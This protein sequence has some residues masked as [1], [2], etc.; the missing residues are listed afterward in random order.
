MNVLG[1]LFDFAYEAFNVA[2][3]DLLEQILAAL[4]SFMKGARQRSVPQP[5]KSLAALQCRLF[6]APLCLV[7]PL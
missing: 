4:D 3:Q 1:V 6:I 5:R 2:P 7:L